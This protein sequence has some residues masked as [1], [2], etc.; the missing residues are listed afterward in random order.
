MILRGEV[1]VLAVRDRIVK[2]IELLPIAFHL[3]HCTIAGLSGVPSFSSPSVR[4]RLTQDMKR[5]HVCLVSLP[6]IR[7][8]L[9]SAA[10]IVHCCCAV[11]RVVWVFITPL[12]NIIK[13]AMN[14]QR[15][16][17]VLYKTP[18]FIICNSL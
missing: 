2:E 18:S 8:N 5:E 3:L 15:R 12:Q 14:R 17:L 7:I 6:A 4:D 10:L 13:L 9:S 1:A 11:F 16:L